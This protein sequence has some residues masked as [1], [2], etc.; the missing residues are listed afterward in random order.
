VILAR[1]TSVLRHIALVPDLD[2]FQTGRG[3]GLLIE[4]AYRTLLNP[5]GFEYVVPAFIWLF[6]FLLAA[7]PVAMP[8]GGGVLEQRSRRALPDSGSHPARDGG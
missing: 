4:F 1:A 2:L 3:A 6:A 7:E 5:P 8:D